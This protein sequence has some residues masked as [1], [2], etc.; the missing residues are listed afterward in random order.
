VILAD[1]EDDK[2]LACAKAAKAEVI[3]SGDSHLLDLKTYEG[4][5]ILT[6]NQFLEQVK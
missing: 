5:P 2:V 1:P 3:T 6:V 4:I